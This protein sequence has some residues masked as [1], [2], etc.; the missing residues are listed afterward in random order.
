MVVTG[1]DKGAGDSARSQI[2]A[3]NARETSLERLGDRM[4]LSD[5]I[6]RYLGQR[7]MRDRRGRAERRRWGKGKSAYNS[8]VMQ[9]INDAR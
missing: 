9:T 2:N 3:S 1:C 8:H 5:A 7:Q 4:K 6:E